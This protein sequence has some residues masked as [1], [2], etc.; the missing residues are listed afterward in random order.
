[1]SAPSVK[2]IEDRPWENPWWKPS[3]DNYLTF[4]YIIATHILAIVGLF[5]FPLPSLR[6][7][8]LS[9]VLAFLGGLGTTVCY[10]RALSHRSLKLNPIIEHVLI[11]FTILNGN[12][13]P[14]TWVANHRQH[15]AKADTIE[16]V[17]SPRHGGFWWAHLR[18]VYQWP[19]SEVKRWCPDM[20]TRIYRFWHIM[21]APIIFFSLCSGLILGWQG[22]FWLGAI[23]MVY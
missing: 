8:I 1:M 9:L 15:H 21:L 14:L 6:V 20:D 3:K 4:V 11:F 5:Y 7:G 12:G 23:R 16:D 13:S 17:S 10:H 19:A 18:W 22:F 2:L